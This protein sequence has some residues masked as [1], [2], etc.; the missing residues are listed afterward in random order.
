[1][2]ELILI[3]RTISFSFY[4]LHL[5]HFHKTF[6]SSSTFVLLKML[7]NQILLTT[8]SIS[9]ATTFIISHDRFLL[10]EFALKIVFSPDAGRGRLTFM[11]TISKSIE[12]SSLF[13]F[14][15]RIVISSPIRN[16]LACSF[17]NHRIAAVHHNR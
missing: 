8:T 4:V 14:D 11:P 7:K 6:S 2:I 5:V 15:T 10:P 17:T 3:K 16:T 13:T 9:I 1:M 12:R